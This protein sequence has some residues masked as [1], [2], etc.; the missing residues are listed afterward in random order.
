[1][2]ASR[3]VFLAPCDF[4]DFEGAVA[5]PVDLPDIEG[6]PGEARVWAVPEGDQSSSSFEKMEEGDLLLFYDGETFVGTGRIGVTFEDD[7]GAVGEAVGDADRTQFY[8]VTEFTPVE[9]PRAAVNQIF[10]YSAGWNPGGLLRVADSRVANSPEA[11]ELALEQ[12]DS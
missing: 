8:T 10:E 3:N 4:G 6:V 2:S 12:Y 9:V 5:S 1:M 11:I 7:G